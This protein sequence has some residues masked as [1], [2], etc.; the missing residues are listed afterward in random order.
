MHQNRY[1]FNE[2]ILLAIRLS[3]KAIIYDLDTC[4]NSPEKTV[5]LPSKL[6]YNSGKAAMDRAVAVHEK[7]AN[8]KRCNMEEN[9][10]S[11]LPKMD[12]LLARPL[13]LAARERVPYPA[14]RRAAR[15]R[16]DELR[17]EAAAGGTL[18]EGDTLERQIIAAAEADCRPRLR[19]VINAT[20]VVLH[21]NLG[22]APLAARAADAARDA[23]LGYS[24]LEYDLEAGARGSRQAFVEKLLC[25]IT[26][27]EA[28]LAVNNNAA[29]VLLMLA[30][31]AAGKRVA[32]SRGELVEIGGAFRV[33]EIMACGGAEL[34]E[35][36][37]TNKTRL[38]DYEN[39]V[40][41]Q[42][43]Q[44]LL[45]VHTSNY[46]IV[47]FTEE[48]SLF[49]LAP[50]AR[51]RGIPLLYDLGSG[52]PAP[53]YLP[54]FSG[55]PTA[56]EALREGAD[57]VC[58]SGD[59]LLGGPQAGI[60]LG[61]QELIAAMRRH[62][63]ARAARI[64]KLSLAALE[65]T[66]LLLRSPEEAREQIPV[67]AMLGAPPEKLRRRA[68]ELAVRLAPVLGE[69]CAVSVVPA[70]GQVGGGSLPNREV[71]GWAAALTPA[72][73]RAQV[74]ERALRR[75]RIPIL[76]RVHRGALLLDVRTLLPGDEEEILRAAAE[77][78]GGEEA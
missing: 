54:G 33:P 11:R 45:K 40:L 44:V 30:A 35:V 13:L 26:G 71:P 6:W 29:A 7:P 8:C 31:L 60:L 74:L 55:V 20:G 36:G 52:L 57:V 18:P 56:A 23:A 49:A 51:A 62:P 43:A 68:E 4:R 9:P 17:Q 46:E 78:A 59:K 1:I 14:L 32:V 58:F 41:S 73:G 72:D 5:P 34:C 25:S 24:N 42:N 65:A 66:L 10:L 76:G 38:S 70:P 37:T 50:L 2:M 39:A 75:R 19:R 61:K 69:N 28:A 53:E 67:L 22:R 16:L 77:L 63:L 64:D 3:V 27:A 21:T 48:T 47:G 12:M 15:V